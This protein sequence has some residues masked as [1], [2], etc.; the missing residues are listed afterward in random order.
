MIFIDLVLVGFIFW[1]LKMRG[2]FDLMNPLLL[3][4]SFHL[5]FVSI[6]MIQIFILGSEIISNKWYNRHLTTDEL[7]PALIA[8][9]LCLLGFYV[10]FRSYSNDFIKPLK[11]FAYQEKNKLLVIVLLISTIIAGIIGLVLFSGVAQRASVDE[12]DRSVFT[13]LLTNA[14]MISAV[15]LIYVRGFKPVYLAYLGVLVLAYS[16]QGGERYRVVLPLIFLASLYI[17][18]NSLR[19]IP[20]KFIAAGFIVIIITFSLKG[21]GKEFQRS[22]HIDFS[23]AF[24]ESYDE[25]LEGDSGDLSFIEQSAAM[26]TGVNESNRYFYGETYL[27]I[28]FFWV[29]KAIWTEKPALNDWQGQISS[30]GRE[31]LVLG[32]ISLLSG[33]AYANFGYLGAF[34][35]P[36]LV[37]RLYA[38]LYRTYR[39]RDHQH[40]GFLA[41]LLFNMVL[42]QVWRDG[43]I[44]LFLFPILNYLPIFLLILIKRNAFNFKGKSVVNKE[45][46]EIIS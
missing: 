40:R 20:L 26:I 15:L 31:F 45:R 38:Y 9:D 17:K 36:F 6:R 41:L 43:L 29:P 30:S 37:G 5:G 12:V 3:F 14:G 4:A 21:I 16:L 32:Q 25:T 13:S 19:G 8:A 24:L 22:G 35:V 34:L 10:G 28:F 7:W 2:E 44:S 23:S 42:F 11:S 1:S 39:L 27:P 46:Y 33:E 18:R